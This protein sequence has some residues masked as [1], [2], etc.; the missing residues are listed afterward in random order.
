VR[1]VLK[2]APTPF[3]V[4]NLINHG[5]KKSKYPVIISNH[6]FQLLFFGVKK[7]KCLPITVG[8]FH[9]NLMVLWSFRN[10][11]KQPAVLWIWILQIPEPNGSS[12]PK[13]FTWYPGL[14]VLWFWF[15]FKEPEPMGIIKIKYPAQTG[16]YREQKRE[17][18][19]GN[20]SASQFK[21]VQL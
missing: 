10:T 14:V 4:S 19:S 13:S 2:T 8:F 11:R 1:R 12:I 20:F 21:L 3:W 5:H 9:V 17:P 6:D 7:I 15:F 18:N 16:C